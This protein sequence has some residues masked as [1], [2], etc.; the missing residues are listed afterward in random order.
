MSGTSGTDY[1]WPF[2]SSSDGGGVFSQAKTVISLKP[3]SLPIL[4]ADICGSVLL[5]RRW[6]SR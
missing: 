6:N 3:V 2:L 1:G 5:R 4:S